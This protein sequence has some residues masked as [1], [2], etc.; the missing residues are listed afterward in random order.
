MARHGRLNGAR[1]SLFC[2]LSDHPRLPLDAGRSA[3]LVLD[4]RVLTPFDLL[5]YLGLLVAVLRYFRLLTTL[6]L[7]L[8]LLT[9]RPL[10]DLDLSAYPRLLTDRYLLP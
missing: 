7:L 8:Y 4:L 9:D 10:T 2:S 3:Y 1:S 6:D 5:P